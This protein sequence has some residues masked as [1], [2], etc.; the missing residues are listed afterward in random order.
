MEGA[1]ICNSDLSETSE[2]GDISP[3][4]SRTGEEKRVLYEWDLFLYLKGKLS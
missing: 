3:E 1:E 4:V 2:R